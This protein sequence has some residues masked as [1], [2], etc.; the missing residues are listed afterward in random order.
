MREV[1]G[2][3]EGACVWRSMSILVNGSPTKEVNIQGGLKQGGLLAPFL[4]LLV[5]EGFSGLLRNAVSLNLFEGFEFRNN[6][7]V[8]SHLQYVD[9]TFLYR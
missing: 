7:L 8:V 4:F 5:A 2:L 6:N 3:D 1:S 9:D